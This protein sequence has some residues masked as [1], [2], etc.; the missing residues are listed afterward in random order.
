M[1]EYQLDF[2]A[3]EFERLARMYCE[4]Q[5][6]VVTHIRGKS[7]RVMSGND[8]ELV[9]EGNEFHAFST[10]IDRAFRCI[11]SVV[12]G[13]ITGSDPKAIRILLPRLRQLTLLDRLSDV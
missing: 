5:G 4:R 1:S 11:L 9:L 2:R 13:K 10:V 7:R 8:L 12:D 3:V 6:F